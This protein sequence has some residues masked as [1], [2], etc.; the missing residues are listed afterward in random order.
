MTVA[1]CTTVKGRLQHLQVTLPTNLA[2][3]PGDA[4]FIVLDYN[5][6]DGLL[7]YLK[8]NHQKDI[9]SGK[10]VVYSFTEPGPFK[11]AHAKN[12]AHRLGIL[13]GAEILC[14]LDAD[15]FTGPGFEYYIED[16]FESQDVYLWAKMIQHGPD[17]L[18]RG[19]TGR[20]VVSKTAFLNAG[21]YDEKYNIWSPD[22]KDFN[23][24]LKRMGYHPLEIDKRFLKGIHHSEKLRFK[25][26]P[27]AHK[28]AGELEY[29]V[30]TDK[31]NTTIVNWGKFGMG[32]VYRN[33]DFNTPI[34][35]CPVP[36]RIFG[37]GMHKTGTTSLHSAL[38]TLGYDSAHWNS[39]A[40]AKAIFQEMKSNKKSS[41]LEK[42]YALT[43][44]PITMLY[45]D[46]DRSYP[47]SKFIL[48]TRN[49]VSWLNS[50]EKHWSYD[51]NEYRAEWDVYPASHML[52]NE[53]YGRKM[54]DADVFLERFRRHNLE[55]QEYFKSRPNDLLV[56]DLDK[57]A[58]WADLCCFLSKPIPFVPYPKEYVSK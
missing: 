41:T 27:H 37:V 56:M 42:H 14:N 53:L 34:I 3:N 12:I 16:M 52:H 23:I 39:G 2:D 36:T 50:V 25:E 58:G 29:A 32:E 13:E 54:F 33:F 8:A 10:L 11:M 17:K 24:R 55:V 20:I 22:D 30:L 1:F 44:L 6:P 48:T 49:E 21:G 46:L 38:T 19:I 51:T 9:D 28:A 31:S 35:L 40:W 4:K 5:S 45:E 26:Y 15:N 43:D 7:D 18:T 47:G 57:N